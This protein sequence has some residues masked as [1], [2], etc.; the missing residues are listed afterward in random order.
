MA[1]ITYEIEYSCDIIADSE[2]INEVIKPLGKDLVKELTNII[3][4]YM[5]VGD[6]RYERGEVFN[7]GLTIDTSR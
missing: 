4:N 2:E 3:N 5:L 1:K 7:I 6:G